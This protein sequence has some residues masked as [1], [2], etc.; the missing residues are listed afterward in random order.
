MTIHKRTRRILAIKALRSQ[1]ERER[2]NL[3]SLKS[4]CSDNKGSELA[5]GIEQGL[6]SLQGA[7][8]SIES[9]LALWEV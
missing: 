9:T 7:L 5:E 3:Q 8:E 6:Q 2:N 4:F 1:I